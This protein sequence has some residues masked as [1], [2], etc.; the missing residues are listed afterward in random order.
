[1]K[2]TRLWQ[3]L[4]RDIIGHLG[5]DVT[6]I[7]RCPVCQVAKGQAQNTGRYIPLPV[8]KDS[9]IDLIMNFVSGLLRIQKG[10]DFIFVVVDRFFK[11]AHFIP[12]RKS[13]NA[14]HA[15]KIFFQEVVRLHG[16]PSFIVLDRDSKLLETF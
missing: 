12:Y 9:W 10:V 4:K 7:V 5:K 15:A 11:M 13:S 14:S 6:T 1:L 8:P 16:V 2:E 3:V